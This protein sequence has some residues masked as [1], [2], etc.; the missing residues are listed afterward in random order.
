MSRLRLGQFLATITF[1]GT[2]AACLIQ[3][4]GASP[5][6][7]SFQQHK[8]IE[9]GMNQGSPGAA[10]WNAWNTQQYNPGQQPDQ[11][12]QVQQGG[13]LL[14][15]NSPTDTTG[16]P[17]SANSQ[18]TMLGADPHPPAGVPFTVPTVK[19]AHFG[20]PQPGDMPWHVWDYLDGNLN[21]MNPRTAQ[22]IFPGTG[23]PPSNYVTAAALLTA[24]EQMG[25]GLASPSYPAEQAAFQGKVQQAERASGQAAQNN[26]SAGAA[27]VQQAL[28]NVANE[29]TASP[30]T[31]GSQPKTLPQAIWMVQQ[32]YKAIFLPMAILLVLPGAVITQARGMVQAA[33]SQD[34]RPPEDAISPFTGILRALIAIFLIP[35]TQLIISYSIDIGN[36]LTYEVQSFIDNPSITNWVG[37]QTVGTPPANVQQQMQQ[38]QSESGVAAMSGSIFNEVNMLLTYG[39]TILICY[40][41]VMMCYLF[42]MGPIAAAFFAW[43]SGI[44]SLFKAVIGN[45]LDAVTNL[46]LWRF[47]WCIIL[48]AMSTRI[49]WLSEVGQYNSNDPWEKAVYTSFMVMLTYVPFHPFEFRPG[50]MVD[51]LLQKAGVK[52]GEGC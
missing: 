18:Q 29:N 48:L 40:Q 3:Q 13:T 51:T 25:Q 36:S 33:F 7:Y 38:E 11:Y 21:G 35:A 2:V 41:I 28:I 5:I 44:N 37:Q 10:D 31:S 1:I 47:W 26:F 43:P 50:E 20:Y 19:P 9:R 6:P 22:N 34:A 23:A 52:Q 17:L 15:G 32:V 4:A 8:Q 27:M 39:I 12:N 16:M 42:L 24:S 14:T 49:H 30:V 45:W 46:A